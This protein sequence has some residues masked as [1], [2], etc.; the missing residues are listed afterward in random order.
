MKIKKIEISN[1][2]WI[3]Y[4]NWT[5]LDF[6]I[7]EKL[8]VLD[9][10]NGFWKTTLFDVIEFCFTGTISRF[11]DIAKDNR[12]DTILKNKNCK[13]KESFVKII[14]ND[15]SF[16]SRKI[17]I[18]QTWNFNTNEHYDREYTCDEEFLNINEENLKNIFYVSQEN[19][20][21]LLKWSK[22][23]FK[24]FLDIL[25]D[26]TKE[27]DFK[28]NNFIWSNKLLKLIDRK[29]TFFKWKIKDF[30]DEDS[31]I[32]DKL[33]KIKAYEVIN[34]DFILIDN[35]KDFSW[36]N[37]EKWAYNKGNLWNNEN[38]F[39]KTWKLLL[40]LCQNRDNL[41][42]YY[43]NE[44]ILS[45]KNPLLESKEIISNNYNYYL[46]YKEKINEDYLTRIDS[47]FFKYKSYKNN[48]NLLKTNGKSLDNIDTLFKDLSDDNIYY[49]E[50]NEVNNNF[51]NFKKS[52]K[53]KTKNE[54]E[55]SDIFTNLIDFWENKFQN[56]ENEE[57]IIDNKNHTIKSNSCPL[58]MS[59]NKKDDIIE[60]LKFLKEKWWKIIKD[61]NNN[62]YSD[63]FN[64]DLYD[65][66]KNHVDKLE[67]EISKIKL[68]QENKNNFDKF[69]VLSKKYNFSE[70]DNIIWINSEEDLKDGDKN[71]IIWLLNNI[72]LK[73]DDSYNNIENFTSTDY[74]KYKNMYFDLFSVQYSDKESLLNSLNL[75]WINN[76]IKYFENEYKIISNKDKNNLEFSYKLNRKKNDFFKDRKLF[77]EWVYELLDKYCEI[78]D[79]NIKTYKKKKVQTIALPLYIFTQ[80]IVKNYNWMWMFLTENSINSEFDWNNPLYTLSS[81]QAEWLSLALMLSNN[82]NY[83]SKFNSILIDDPIQSLDD[84][85]ILSFINLLR[86]QFFDKQI[87]ISTH[88]DS[89]S[90]FI[91][92][93]FWRLYWKNSY[94]QINMK[95]K[96]LEKNN[97]K[98]SS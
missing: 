34:I 48:L 66:I 27:V 29:V 7:W 56:I 91:R 35:I 37:I 28:K 70:I 54:K 1:F 21:G 60:Q 86:Y 20:T 59:E 33:D 72:L 15:D 77:L 5:L 52:L 45:F 50:L 93:K 90:R 69:I 49:S 57:L 8:T 25:L 11:E 76:N 81:G 23:W 68:L 41:K 31:K 62:F 87:I 80:R 55:Y 84:L 4:Y 67:K 79:L 46:Y 42:Q 89:F 65:K 32:K 36:Y 16:I 17:S 78:I 10:E 83:N 47:I 38:S 85:N 61:W 74:Q 18:N 71:I 95:R 12:P 22:D 98:K 51:V 24:S 26:T 13:D 43:I 58:C 96:F 39:I 88:D 3:K 14:F 40:D 63:L 19:P 73:L 44:S 2:R 9:W 64:N 94:E 92:Y 53:Q 30:A 75:D 82:I 6:D 97:I